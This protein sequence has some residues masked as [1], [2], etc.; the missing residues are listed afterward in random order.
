[1]VDT[2]VDRA[3]TPARARRP[4]TATTPVAPTTASTGAPG[5]GAPARLTRST[6]AWARIVGWPAWVQ[7]LLA[8]AA[9][10]V[11][12]GVLIEAAAVFVQNPAGVQDVHPDYLDMT[13]IWDGDWYRK[14]AEQGYPSRLPHA[15]RGTVDYNGW[16]F[17][18]VFPMLARA[19]MAL[20]VP[21]S[22]AAS[23]INLVAGAGAALLIWKLF[24]AR[25]T[26]RQHD[27]LAVLA[28]ALWCV[29]PPSP[30]LQVAY[31]EAL[32]ALL[33]AGTL[34]L[35]VRRHYLWAVPV[36]LL[37]GLTRAVAAPLVLVVAWHA[38]LRWRRRR[39]EPWP[40]SSRWALVGL[41]LATAVSAVLWPVI[42][43]WATGVPSAF[44]ETQAAWGQRPGAGPFLPWLGWAWDHL[45]VVGVLLLVGVVVFS[46]RQ[47][48]GRHTAWLASEV[49]VFGVVYPVYLL[50]VL[51]PITS[52]WRFLL[53]DLPIAA[54]LASAAARGALGHTVSPRWRW[55]VC[56][57]V[58]VGLVA[59][60]WWVM[61]MLTRVPWAD[62]PP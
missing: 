4:A 41:A 7:V 16:A 14:I 27:R 42:A 32:A 3:G 36:V 50:A 49:R 10:R 57:A 34:L 51:R 61:V 58:L 1:M 56:A 48:A 6:R 30:V 12:A 46:L 45:G 29:L 40:A 23:M 43:G 15:A 8:Y 9:S 5:P 37:L 52:M 13:V 54:V 28:V 39:E 33:L 24:A 38:V 18:P 26:G 22:V 44:F 25:S 31:T 59:M 35:L 60:A 47:L 20:G 11:L 2:T 55:R 19:V 62:S 17:F 21:F 53:L